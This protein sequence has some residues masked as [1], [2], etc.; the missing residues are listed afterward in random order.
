MFA[1]SIESSSEEWG[2]NERFFV[3]L[4]IEDDWN[5]YLGGVAEGVS[6]SEIDT[7]P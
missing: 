4:V 3:T 2:S 7:T 5:T 6:S 1:V